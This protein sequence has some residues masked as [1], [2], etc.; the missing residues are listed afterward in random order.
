MTQ[1]KYA[2]HS[3]SNL[4]L[5]GMD[6]SNGISLAYI[7]RITSIL[8]G[9][10][11]SVPLNF[12]LNLDVNNPNLSAALLHGLQYMLS[13]DNVNFTSGTLQQSLDIP[14]GGSQLLP[15]VIGLDLNT[16]L[17]G[18]SK[19]AVVNIAKNFIGIGNQPSNVTFRIK[20]T[21]M[22][23][24]VPVTAPDYIPVSFSFGGGK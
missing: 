24:N 12:T 15:L 8:T 4:S 11:S 5:S 16:L 21:F 10:S 14:A 22:I 6:L 18:E 7:P 9:A 17:K 20:P 23:G 1:C 3:I 2:Y 19:D 13:I